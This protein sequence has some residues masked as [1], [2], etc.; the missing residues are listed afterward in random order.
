MADVAERP[1]DAEPDGGKPGKKEKKDKKESQAKKEPK[2][3]KE[4]VPQ[5]AS[6]KKSEGPLISIT[7]AKKD[8]LAEWYSQVIVKS[9]MLAFYDISGCYILESK[10][11]H[12]W[13][14]T[15]KPWFKGKIKS[16]GVKDCIYPL[17]IP[18][19]Y[20]TKEKDHLE[21]FEAEVAW[22]THGG[23]S[24]LEKRLAIRPTSETAMYTHYAK[25]IQSYRDLP[26]KRN[27]WNSVVRWEFKHPM[28]F[29]RS[30]EFNWQEGHT[31]HLTKDDAAVRQILD[32]Y[33]DIYQE[34]FAC[35][36]VKGMK[37]TKE[38][39]AGADYTTTIEGFIP[40]TGRGIQAATSHHLGQHFSRMFNIKVEDPSTNEDGTKKPPIFAYQN[41]WG[42]TTRSIGVMVLTHGDD[43]GLVLPPRVAE[44]QVVIVPV[45]INNKMTDEDKANLYKKISDL[46][47]R[48]V[49]A[50]IRVMNDTRDYLTAGQKF[51]E[52]ELQGIPLRLEIGPK[53]LEKGVVTTS[54]RDI[55]GEKGTIEISDNF[56]KDIAALLETI[57][58]DLFRRADE[59][60]RAHRKQVSDWTDFVPALNDKNV[61]IVPF[62]EE[63][64]CEDEIKKSS[65][66]TD[67]G[68][69]VAEDA[70]APAMGA[71]SLCI[72]F[73][74]FDLPEGTKCLGPTCERAAKHWTMFGRSY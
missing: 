4:K 31:A 51:N 9:N 40:L 19:E 13:E 49:S 68:D 30:R 74:Q 47:D 25:S 61:C 63:E 14:E 23:K 24:K 57:Q 37:T 27:Q 46:E 45:G 5:P 56:T 8:D 60:Y 35:P 72:P 2:V 36:V 11:M 43:T 28:P 50:N 44:H 15:I 26:H 20:L 66:R 73:E 48:M 1:K 33:A 55:Q 58:S 54:R 42:F 64:A 21:G 17:L 53:D 71:K 69:S 7:V 41:S 3:K 6:K 39:F 52:W 22:V 59:A 67:E 10:T 62:C 38:K 18:E 65:A 29:I 12:I 70:R 32:W 34:L 16:I